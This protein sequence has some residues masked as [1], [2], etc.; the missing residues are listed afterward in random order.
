MLIVGFGRIGTRL[1]SRAI[2]L[3]MNVLVYD[4]FVAADMVRARGC[5]PVAD[6]DAALPGAD[7][8]SLH[9]PK[10]PDTVGLFDAARLANMKRS[11]FLINTARG[12]I[13]DEPALHAALVAGTLA[14]AGLDVYETEPA[15]TDNPL[16]HLPNVISAP[17]MAGVSREALDRMSATAVRNILSV[18]D[19]NPARENVINAEVLG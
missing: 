3:E 9:C 10:K 12:G 18:I 5:T 15:P 4:P 2:A 8:V 16:M 1:A 17:H 14:G 13:V 7:F 19:G 6:L 11:A